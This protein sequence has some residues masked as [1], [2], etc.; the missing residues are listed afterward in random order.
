MR[1]PVVPNQFEVGKNKI[2]HKPTQAILTFDTGDTL[3]KT[4]TW[5]RADEP[6]EGGREYLKDDIMRVA[7]KLLIKIPR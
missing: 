3:F 2:V 4:M 1:T 6:M 5:G 7:Q